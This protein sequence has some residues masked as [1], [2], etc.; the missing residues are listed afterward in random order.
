[1]APNELNQAAGHNRLLLPPPP[2]PALTPSSVEG[3]RRGGSIP[4]AGSRQVL[5]RCVGLGE[6]WDP[7]PSTAPAGSSPGSEGRAGQQ[8]QRF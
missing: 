1:M 6:Y 3:G 7:R 5:V 4:G 2:A 8:L